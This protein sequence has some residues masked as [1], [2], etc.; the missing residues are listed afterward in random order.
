MYSCSPKESANSVSFLAARL[1]KAL[2]I[3]A[4]A[5]SIPHKAAGA[6]IA[7]ALVA[8]AVDKGEYSSLTSVSNSVI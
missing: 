5:L 8:K 2:D 3:L 6:S 7:P 1:D 4:L